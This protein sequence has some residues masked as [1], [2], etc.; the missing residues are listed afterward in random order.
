LRRALVNFRRVV[1]KK[2]ALKRALETTEIYWR[3]SFH[4]PPAGL[5]VNL[6]S[7]AYSDR[8]Q[9]KKPVPFADTR[10]NN[11]KHSDFAQCPDNLRWIL[12]IVVLLPSKKKI[13]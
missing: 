13:G 3:T 10:R 12:L 6:N 7:C 8:P 9:I 1:R 5:F 2:T 4:P 11:Q